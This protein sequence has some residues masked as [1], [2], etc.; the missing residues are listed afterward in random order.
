M[1]RNI[2]K[3]IELLR[4]EQLELKRNLQSIVCLKRLTA[5]DKNYKECKQERWREIE[6]NIRLLEKEQK[7]NYLK[8]EEERLSNEFDLVKE[9]REKIE[10]KQ[11]ICIEYVRLVEQEKLLDEERI[12]TFRKLRGLR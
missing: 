10:Q 6:E 12:D 9:Q 11:P 3:E 8:L 1:M 5:D 7:F 4:K 2:Q